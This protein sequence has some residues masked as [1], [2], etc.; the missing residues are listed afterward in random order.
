MKYMLDGLSL[1]EKGLF[2]SYKKAYQDAINRKDA[3]CAKAYLQ[4]ME[5]LRLKSVMASRPYD[6]NVLQFKRR[7]K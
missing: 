6:N 7:E 5:D 4:R 3:L 1:Y 2:L